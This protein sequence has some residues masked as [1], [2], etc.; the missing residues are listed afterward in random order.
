MED[1]Y[2]G[3]SEWELSHLPPIVNRR[4]HIVL[5]ELPIDLNATEPPKPHDGQMKWDSLHVRLPCS[6][7]NEYIVSDE[8][9]IKFILIFMDEHENWLS[10]LCTFQNDQNVTVKKQRWEIIQNALLQPI[11]TSRDLEKAILSYNTKYAKQWKFYALHE[12]FEEVETI[13]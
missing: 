11:L 1:I 9:R 8:V 12:L 2:R 3:L 10:I 4:N 5:F 13:F 6:P 7:Q